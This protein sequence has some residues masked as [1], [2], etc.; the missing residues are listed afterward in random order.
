MNAREERDDVTNSRNSITKQ[1]QIVESA[2]A[3]LSAMRFFPTLDLDE[4]RCQ[5]TR[6]LSAC[7]A[8]V[9]RLC[10]SI[11]RLEQEEINAFLSHL[12]ASRTSQLE[13]ST[14]YASLPVK[15]SLRSFVFRN[16][17]TRSGM[18]FIGSGL[19]FGHLN[20]IALILESAKRTFN[21]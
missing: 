20:C 1:H 10:S 14:R 4:L 19:Y 6:L 15:P 2:W 13:S 3:D 21:P 12:K 9:Q 7:D 18:T 16:F 17:E 11:A 5:T 8:N